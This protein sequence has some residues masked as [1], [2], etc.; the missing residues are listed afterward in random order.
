[1]EGGLPLG[2]SGAHG[3]AD[4]IAHVD[5]LTLSHTENP[6][7]ITGISEFTFGFA[8]LF[9][10]THRNWNGLTAVPVLPSLQQEADDAWD[11]RLPTLAVDY[12]YQFKLSDYLW[13]AHAKFRKDGTYTE[14]YFRIALHRRDNNRQHRRLKKHAENH[15][16]TYYVAPEFTELNDFN[17]SFLAR[18]IT[19]QTRLIPVRECDDV[20]DGDQ[21]FITYQS[22]EER[23]RQHSQPKIHQRSESG[24]DLENVY[25]R[26]RPKWKEVDNEFADEL[27]ETTRD[28][29]LRGLEDEDLGERDRLV[30]SVVDRAPNRRTTGGLLQATAEMVSVYYG[31]TMV[32]V[33]SRV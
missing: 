18:E 19:Q 24:I 25:R 7:A 4:R 3:Y 20:A 23:W 14:P 21:H 16:E 2:R 28:T 1:M 26:S 33:G 5:L 27:L 29:I 9:E 17:D 6:M 11:A 32:L 13:A 15:P 12:Y 30:R 22:G 10:Q 31:A 8:F